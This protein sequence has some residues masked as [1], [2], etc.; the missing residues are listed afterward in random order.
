MPS[1]LDA[2][3]AARD[4]LLALHLVV[5]GLLAA[6]GI[7][8]LHL[9]RLFR[10]RD[11]AA[12][13]PVPPETWPRVTIQLPVYNERYVP[14]G[15]RRGGGDG[16]SAALPRDQVL[17]DSTDETSALIAAKAAVLRARGHDVVHLRRAARDGFKA[18][19]LQHVNAPRQGGLL[20]I[21]D[22]DS[23]RRPPF[24]G[25]SFRT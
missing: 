9:L 8:R 13:R 21:L 24:C 16:L 15:P 1:L 19:A 5:W 18:G 7:H 22:A 14:S 11:R 6:Y 2:I 17:D 4:S 10:R 25:T 3:P 20:A 12:L 23:F